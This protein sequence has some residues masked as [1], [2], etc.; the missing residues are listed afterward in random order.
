[1]NKIRRVAVKAHKPMKEDYLNSLT[2]H[3]ER[4][5]EPDEKFLKEKLSEV[6][7]FRKI[8]LASA[9]KY[10]SISPESIVYMVRNGKAYAT[11]FEGG[12]REA[13]RKTLGIESPYERYLDI[14]KDAIVADLNLEEVKV[15]MPEDVFYAVPTTEKQFVGNIPYGSYV[16]VSDKATVGIYWED[17]EGH[18]VDL[19]LALISASGKFGWD[20]SYRSGGRGVM[21]SG[22]L[23][24][25]PKGA[26]EH[27][28]VEGTE[29]AEYLMTVNYFNYSEKH[30]VPTKIIV[31]Q[32]TQALEENHMVHPD[33]LR[34]VLP[35]DI[36]DKQ[37]VLG[38]LS[39]REDEVRFY[40][41][42][43]SMGASRS[44]RNNEFVQHARR[45]LVDFY[46]NGLDLREL[47]AKA[48]VVFVDREE[49][50]VDLSLEVL[51]KDSILGLLTRGD[52]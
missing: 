37:H 17:L 27:F 48:G 11:A 16:S 29:P 1:V 31:A 52:I 8:R 51:E 35:I 20:A 33:D 9:I 22:D 39:V 19:D 24:S 26:A 15:H 28:Y 3:I 44:S 23:T 43:A 45:Y 14:V 42:G 46:Q 38:L 49:A 41:T 7:I 25:A 21:F 12:K 50:E 4:G 40:F 34:F 5:D 13:A 32:K 2:A 10:R 30:P 6:N 47:L 18:R 36:T